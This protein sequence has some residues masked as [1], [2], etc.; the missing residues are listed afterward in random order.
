MPII[1]SAS[2]LLERDLIMELDNI[3]FLKL[4]ILVESVLSIAEV[5][6]IKLK[7]KSISSNC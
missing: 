4:E 3:T 6:Y 1:R 7:I 5:V 2:P